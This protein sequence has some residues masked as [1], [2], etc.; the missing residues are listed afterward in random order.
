[1]VDVKSH[2]EVKHLILEVGFLSFGIQAT[3]VNGAGY[4]DDTIE[5]REDL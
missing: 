5:R 4:A 3:I 2:I 1:M